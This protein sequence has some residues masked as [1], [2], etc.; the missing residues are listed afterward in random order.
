[1]AWCLVVVWCVVVVYARPHVLEEWLGP[2]NNGGAVA[3]PPDDTSDLIS[4]Q[5]YK[6]MT[7][8]C[9]ASEWAESH[10]KSA[11]DGGMRSQ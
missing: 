10:D 9:C 4:C 5:D 2:I 3:S 1:M 7:F 6:P 11:N 8:A